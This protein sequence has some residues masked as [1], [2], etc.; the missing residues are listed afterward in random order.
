MDFPVA[1]RIA[2]REQKVWRRMCNSPSARPSCVPARFDLRVLRASAL[3]SHVGLCDAESLAQLLQVHLEQLLLHL[4]LDA[5]V[6]PA[7]ACYSREYQT[8]CAVSW[9]LRSENMR[10]PRFEHK[11]S[12]IAFA[13]PIDRKSLAALCRPHH[14]RRLSLFGSVL[15]PDFRPESDVDV[16]VDFDWARFRVFSRCT[17]SRGNSPNC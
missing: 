1:P 13:I 15:R 8:T 12:S 6:A 3:S 7:R 14:I 2:S 10:P 16:L 11:M 4:T 5:R 9:L 17:R